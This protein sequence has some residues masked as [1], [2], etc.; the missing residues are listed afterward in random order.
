MTYI[1]DDYTIAKAFSKENL[2][3][4]LLLIN[5]PLDNKEGRAFLSK[6]DKENTITGNEVCVE[7]I[8][9]DSVVGQS[10]DSFPFRIFRYFTEYTCHDE[11]LVF[12]EYCKQY[13]DM[14]SSERLYQVVKDGDKIK[15][16]QYR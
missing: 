6:Y 3:A 2:Q 1:F 9:Y 8:Y 14:V 16:G 7:G 15:V 5:S 13:S 4:K 11:Y 10:I 12:S